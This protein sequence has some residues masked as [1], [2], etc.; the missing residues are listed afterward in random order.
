MVKT[1]YEIETQEGRRR[2]KRYHFWVDHEFLRH[3]WTNFDEI[4][5]GVFRSNHPT[6]NRLEAYATLGIKSVLT[7]RGGETQPHQ[8]LEV[9]ACR[10]LGLTLHCL[11]M[12]AKSAPTLL[13]L[14]K[15]FDV[16]D[17]IKHP[18]LMHCKSGADRTGLLSAIYLLQYERAKIQAGKAQLSLRYLHI[19]R[20]N[21]GI[22]DFF[23][24]RLRGPVPA[25]R[26]RHP[27]LDRNRVQSGSVDCR[28]H[29]APEIIAALVRLTVTWHKSHRP[30]TRLT[31]NHPPLPWL[32]RA[33][34]SA[35]ELPG[36]TLCPLVL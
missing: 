30:A 17:T 27:Q 3:I 24:R 18:F 8:L 31:E 5:P 34:I 35:F 19:K 25:N 26:H 15:A 29:S 1:V 32:L 21:S 28:I 6:R 22:L 9:E 11:P 12:S 23:Y 2:V 13:Q 14:N 20:A 16:F 36:N 7:L 4:A 10:Q 33:N